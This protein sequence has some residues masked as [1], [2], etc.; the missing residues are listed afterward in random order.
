MAH[1]E[2]REPLAEGDGEEFWV[3]RDDGPVRIGATVFR[4]SEHAYWVF[5]DAVDVDAAPL[6]GAIEEFEANIW[7]TVTGLFGDMRPSGAD[8][9]PRLVI[10]HSSLRT[11]VAGYYSSADEYPRSIQPLSNERQ[12][13]YVDVSDLPPGSRE[14]LAVLAHELQHAIHWA[15]DPDEE[16]WLNEGLSELA[17]ERTGYRPLNVRAYLRQPAT[18]LTGWPAEVKTAGAHYGAAMLFV[19]YLVTHYGGDGAISRLV[20]EPADGLDGVDSYLAGLGVEE[21]ALDVFADWVVTNYLDDAGEPYS[22]ADRSLTQGRK[23]TSQPV[24]AGVPMGS[25]VGQFGARYYAVRPDAPT[26]RV[27]FRGV[28]T[29]ELFPLAPP[30][31]RACWWGNAGDSI[32][33]TLT[34]EIDLGTA[35]SATL[36][37]KVWHDIE[38]DWDYAYVEVSGDG[39]RTWDILTPRHASDSDPNGAAYGPGYTGRTEGWLSDQVDLSSYAG[40]RVMVRFE[41][42]TDDAVHLDGIC[43][44]DFEV[45]EIG[46]S[47]DAESDGGWTAEGFA[48][49]GNR[50]QQEYLVQIVTDAGDDGPVVERLPIAPDGSGE[51]TLSTDGGNTMIVVIVSAVTS[52]S[53]SDAPYTLTIEPVP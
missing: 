26:V 36:R 21:S 4:V 2:P 53:R 39:G 1:P 8:G 43:L 16:T 6:D 13:I 3:H 7:P 28:S 30:S 50:I 33:A 52:A 47:D 37:W 12:V 5:D 25:R 46:W 35:E 38:A 22:Y 40:G 32:D 27:A 23:A 48:R 24:V 14:Y 17:M 10:L 18:S 11:G 19:E 31:G 34:R 42:V 51:T 9:G 49:V 41:Y 29:A 15:A 44:D 45:P 20:Q